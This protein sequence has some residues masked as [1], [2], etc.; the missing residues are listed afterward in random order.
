[1]S[2]E[3]AILPQYEDSQATLEL[4]ESAPE[5]TDKALCARFS[6]ASTILSAVPWL[7]IGVLAKSEL[8]ADNE[9]YMGA[10]LVAILAA[11]LMALTLA[12]LSAQVAWPATQVGRYLAVGLGLGAST[13]FVIVT[14]ESSAYV[15]YY[16]RT[17]MGLGG[18]YAGLAFEVATGACQRGVEYRLSTGS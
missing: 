9:E 10:A 6:V 8:Y 14:Y 3:K 11:Q 18:L 5:T 4:I 13:V 15:N 7:I 17:F 12:T 16:A 2:S 1:M